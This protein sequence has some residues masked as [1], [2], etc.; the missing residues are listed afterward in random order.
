MNKGYLCLDERTHNIPVPE[1]YIKNKKR[2]E[3]K[4]AEG[5][6]FSTRGQNPTT[7]FASERLKTDD[8]SSKKKSYLCLLHGEYHYGRSKTPR[9]SNASHSGKNCARGREAFPRRPAL[10][11][12]NLHLMAV[13]EGTVKKSSPRALL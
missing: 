4:A 3:I 12:V 6:T 11:K 10:V 2:T 1:S 5:S 8:F 9:V 7:I 13:V